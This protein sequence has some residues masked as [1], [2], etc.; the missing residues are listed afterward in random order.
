MGFP[1]FLSL[2]LLFVSVPATPS[3]S[4][5]NELCVLRSLKGGPALPKGEAAKLAREAL[6]PYD[7][8]LRENLDLV[9]SLW[10]EGNDA[11]HAK[12]VLDTTWDVCAAERRSVTDALTTVMRSSGNYASPQDEVKAAQRYRS[13]VAVAMYTVRFMQIG[14]MAAL[15]AL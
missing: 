3:D 10:P 9:T 11:E 13:G 14:R 1:L 8:C 4:C 15:K 5:S 7:A 12:F 2:L 6:R